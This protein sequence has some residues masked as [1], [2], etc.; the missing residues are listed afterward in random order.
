VRARGGDGKTREESVADGT[1]ATVLVRGGALAGDGDV[2]AHEA[3]VGAGLEQPGLGGEAGEGGRHGVSREE[4]GERSIGDGLQPRG[5][6]A[7]RHGRIGRLVELELVKRDDVGAC[8]LMDAGED[9]DGVD[10]F[11]VQVCRR[12]GGGL[13]VVVDGDAVEVVQVFDVVDDDGEGARCGECCRSDEPRKRERGGETV[14]KTERHGRRSV[15][16]YG[17]DAKGACGL[18]GAWGN[19]AQTPGLAARVDAK[20]GGGTVAGYEEHA[21]WRAGR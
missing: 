5:V 14:R 3:G 11:Y 9:G 7:G 15:D 8:A 2:V 13:V 21:W 10:E 19:R 16:V 1:A 18:A 6:V 17:R 20:G 4:G 12:P